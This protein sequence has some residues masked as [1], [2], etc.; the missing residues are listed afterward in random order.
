MDE[1]KRRVQQGIHL[2]APD[3]TL[4]LVLETDGSDDGWGAVLYQMV[5]GEKRIIKM[6]SK[7][8]KTEAWHKKP[9]YHRE[10]KA[11]MNGMTLAMPY[12]ACNP[13][14]L[15]CWTDHSPLT[16]VKHTSGKGPVSQFIIDTLSNVDYEMNYFQ[17]KDNV[18]SDG[19]SRFPMLRPQTLVRT[20]VA[21]A[22]DILL[23]TLLTSKVDTTKLWF[24]A[25]K[26]TKFLLP[27]IYDWY[28]A[29]KKFHADKHQPLRTCYQ[30]AL[31]ESKLGKLGYTL[32]IWVPPADKICRQMRAA[33]KQNKPFACLV[34]SDLIGSIC[35]MPD[36]TSDK[37][38]DRAV[39]AARK[40]VFLGPSLTWLIHGINIDNT[41]KQVY[42]NNTISPEIE[43]GLLSRHLRN[44][45]IAPPIPTC[46][47][48][49]DW[50]REQTRARVHE[51][52]KHDPRAFK[53]QDGLYVFQEDDTKVPRTIV[54]E[55]LQKSLVKW[56]HHQMCHMS[57]GKL[58]NTLKKKFFFV[59]MN[60]TCQEVVKDCALC[61]LLKARMR[62]AHQHF[63]AKLFCQPRT[64]YGA[65]YY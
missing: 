36:G 21:R 29:R 7:Q 40:I 9:P 6:W 48:R 62:H 42:V 32:G 41:Y 2:Y 25:R 44:K 49:A 17:G 63:R 11:W 57:A 28:D 19:L 24:D 10:A 37:D 14:P 54:P 34:P 56:E 18:I 43:L 12:A 58:Y 65:D 27:N 53:V 33:L 1:L 22:L 59:G 35:V 61:N 38:V 47:T 26:D 60:T 3:N 30:D 50:V 13:F 8:W 55:H 23:A 15:Q 4:P 20:G 39:T 45:D 52:W 16:W 46:R 64:S 31:S 51:T 5:D